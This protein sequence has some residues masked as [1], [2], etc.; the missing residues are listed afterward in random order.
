[1]VG[2][3]TGSREFSHA[4]T[5]LVTLHLADGV[6]FGIGRA[7]NIKN[8]GITFPATKRFFHHSSGNSGREEMTSGDSIVAP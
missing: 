1:M 7:E 8:Q 2:R 4:D 5:E 3:P 6:P